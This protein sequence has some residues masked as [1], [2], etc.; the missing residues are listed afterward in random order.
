MPPVPQPASSTG[1]LAVERP[2][3]RA[4]RPAANARSPRYHHMRSSTACM[5]SYSARSTPCLLLQVSS[6]RPLMISSPCL[7]NRHDQAPTSPAARRTAAAAAAVCPAGPV[8]RRLFLSADQPRR[9]GD[10]RRLGPLAG[11]REALCRGDRREPAAHLHR[12]CPARA[13]RQAAAGQRGVL[14][15][16]LGGGRHLRLVLGLPPAG[17]PRAVGRPCAHRSAAAAGAAVPVLGAAQRAFRPARAHHVRG[18][19]ALSHRL[20]GTR[21]GRRADPRRGDRDRPG[22][23]R[24]ARHEAALPRHPGGGRTLPAGP[25]RLAGDPPRSHPVG[26][27]AGGAGTSRVDVRAL[28]GFRLRRPAARHRSL[29]A[30]RRLRDG[31]TC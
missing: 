27:R 21:R 14:V 17:P 20:D 5:R 8:A 24:G 22:R 30:D 3:A 13:D 23:R 9:G 11:W 6:S 19:R 10:P 16:R 18:L 4:S 1:P 12:A 29:C 28:P 26:D 7:A 31:A 2:R 15:H 25:P